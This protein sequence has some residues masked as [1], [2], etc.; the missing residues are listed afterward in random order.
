MQ[1]F[2]AGNVGAP[3]VGGVSLMPPNGHRTWQESRDSLIEGNRWTIM[4]GVVPVFLTLR[5]GPGSVYGDDKSNREKLAPTEYY[6]DLAVAHH[7][8]M[9]E[10]GLY[11]KMNK[12]RWCPLD[13]LNNHY[14]GELGI[15]ELA[16]NPANWLA[17]TIPDKANWLAKFIASLN[18]PAR[19]Q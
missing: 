16:G 17:D 2:G 6:L 12:L 14:A 10:Y 7:E 4:N 19:I 1:V 15:L 13:C 11:S 18:P 3:F 8:A 9:K 5:L